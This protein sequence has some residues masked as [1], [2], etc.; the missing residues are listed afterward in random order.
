LDPGANDIVAAVEEWSGGHGADVVI[1]T[2]GGDAFT[3][4]RRCIA[5]EG[6]LV[7][8]GFTSGQIPDLRVNHLI[9][10]NFTVMGVN[11]MSYLWHYNRV[12]QQARRAVIDLCLQ[13]KVAPVI[14]GEFPF[15]RAS[16]VLTRLATGQVLGKA[17]I[18][19]S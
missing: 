19:V 18:T 9:L 2:V 10:R 6:R 3:A 8:V 17:V 1:D 12:A 16:E 4:S 7:V 14:F 11:A 13:G 15:E 5:F